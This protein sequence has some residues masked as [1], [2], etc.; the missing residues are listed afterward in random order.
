MRLRISSYARIREI[1]GVDALERSVPDR[2]T[3]GD[4]WLA[5]ARA[6]P[7]LEGLQASTRFVRNGA[8]VAE[9]AALDDGDELTLLPP[10]GGG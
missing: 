6:V 8:F 9:D 4:V 3:A 1:L 7:A 2:A 10:F 5:L